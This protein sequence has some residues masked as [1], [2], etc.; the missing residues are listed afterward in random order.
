MFLK[1]DIYGAGPINVNRYPLHQSEAS[2]R[3][4]EWRAGKSPQAFLSAWVTK[5]TDQRNGFGLY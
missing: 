2:S 5:L 4:A 3:L 1:E